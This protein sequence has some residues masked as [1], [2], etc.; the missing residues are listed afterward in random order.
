MAKASKKMKTKRARKAGPTKP[1][2]PVYMRGTRSAKVSAHNIADVFAM[3]EKHGHGR[4]FR[5]QAKAGDH[6]VTLDPKTVNFVKDFVAK[7]GMH[8]DRIG[9][10]IVNSGGSFNCG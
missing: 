10:Q 3:I 5:Q 7:N 8:G 9:K 1:P 6:V 4:K 2:T